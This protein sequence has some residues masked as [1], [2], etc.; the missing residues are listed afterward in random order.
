MTV[1]AS[2]CSL[3]NLP[4]EIQLHI[5]RYVFSHRLLTFTGLECALQNAKHTWPVSL[6]G[7]NRAI[8]DLARKALEEA[9][10]E[11]KLIYD[12]C[13]PTDPPESCFE[14][15][16]Y[17]KNTKP[18]EEQKFSGPKRLSPL[19]RPPH[20]E[21][22]ISQYGSFI[23]QLEILGHQDIPRWCIDVTPFCNL[24]R[25]LIG[26]VMCAFSCA[27]PERDF[28]IGEQIGLRCVVGWLSDPNG[29]DY[30][31]SWTKS[32]P[33]RKLELQITAIHECSEHGT[34]NIIVNTKNCQILHREMGNGGSTESRKAKNERDE[35]RNMN[36]R[37]TRERM[38][39]KR[40][41]SYDQ[42]WEERW[43]DEAHSERASLL[44]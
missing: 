10:P 34:W 31:A 7:T 15:L 18:S 32:L 33:Q 26:P 6:L 14:H 11:S 43:S 19:K 40:R 23:K 22:F 2:L 38:Q 20:H 21:L 37:T 12:K 24:E 25:V 16:D 5:Y 4:T 1:E 39:Q 3:S 9:L 35:Q 8:S 36:F 13:E 17:I 30:H 41:G 44:N 27:T 42:S 28:C 29:W